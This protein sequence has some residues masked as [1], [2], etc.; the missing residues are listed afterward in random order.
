[1]A[2][3]RDPL[4]SHQPGQLLNR[5]ENKWSRGTLLWCF[6]SPPSLHLFICALTELSAKQP[7]GQDAI[8]HHFPETM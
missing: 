8:L 4:N 2:N 5:E 6:L 7:S 1:M 3:D